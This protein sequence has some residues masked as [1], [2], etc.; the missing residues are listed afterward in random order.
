[1]KRYRFPNVYDE[2]R[3]I[4]VFSIATPLVLQIYKYI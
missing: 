3:I 4:R 1:M 2:M